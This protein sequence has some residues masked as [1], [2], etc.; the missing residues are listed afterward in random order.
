MK[1]SRRVP[2]ACWFLGGSFVVLACSLTVPDEDEL[3][4]NGDAGDGG[5]AGNAVGGGGGIVAQGGNAGS[6]GK[7]AQMGGEAGTWGGGGAIGVGG[8]SGEAGQG[9]SGGSGAQ[10]G[11]AGS[12]GDPATSA[13]AGAGAGQ[14]GLGGEGG[15]GPVV[16][17]FEPDQ[18]LLMHYRFDDTE[19]TAAY[20]EVSA[21]N[22]GVINGTSSWV[23]AGKIGGALR[24]TGQVDSYVD[25]P[26]GF[27]TGQTE[28]S[29]AV[30]FNQDARVPWSR[31]FDFGSSQYHWMYFAPAASQTIPTGMEQG[32]RAALDVANSIVADLHM[33][34]QLQGAGQWVHVVISWKATSFDCY[35]NGVLASQKTNPAYT[36]GDFALRTP[37]A[38]PPLRAYIGR[39]NFPVD[40]HLAGMVDDFRVYDRALTAADVASLHALTE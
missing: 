13:G 10:G 32:A 11:S 30:W 35:I 39:S 38:D 28:M 6:G 21:A 31:V 40:P 23:V 26:P 9:G 1:R 16:V 7:P 20:N 12:G 2:L 17:P 14:A 24:L 4:Q 27:M 22:D 29:V 19:G 37:P 15:G 8:E 3:F 33:P 5:T 18:G 25:I 36:P 34:D